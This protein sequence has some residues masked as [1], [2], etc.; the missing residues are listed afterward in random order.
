VRIHFGWSRHLETRLWVWRSEDNGATWERVIDRPHARAE[1][2]MAI[3][4]AA[5][6]TPY[7]LLHPDVTRCSRNTMRH[8]IAFRERLLARPLTPDRR[9]LLDPIDVLD[10]NEPFG[11]PPALY[12]PLG[13]PAIWRA[14]IASGQTL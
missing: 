12:D 7:V 6:G 14:D 1:T 2:P 9:G 3:G 11:P 5:D 10:C 13:C 8:S 4:Q